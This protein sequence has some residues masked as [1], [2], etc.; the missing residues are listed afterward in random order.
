MNGLL[1]RQDFNAT[2]DRLT[3]WWSGT[4]IGRPAMLIRAPRSAPLED[5]PA[6]AEPAGWLTDYSI[7]NFEYRV[8]LTQ[9]ACINTHFMGEAMP[10]VAPDLGANCLAL[11]LGCKGVESPGTVWIEPCINDPATAAFE[12]DQKNF[13]WN[14]T[15]RLTREQLRLGKG[16]FLLQFPDLIEGLDTLA[17]MRGTESLLKDLVDRPEWVQQ[18][19]QQITRRYFEYYD[20]LFELIKDDRGGSHYCAWAP[21][22]TAKLQCDMSAMISPEMFKEFMVPVLKEMTARLDYCLYHWDGP[23][24]ICHHDQL[25]SMPKLNMIQWNPGAGNEPGS[26]KRWWPLYHK[27]IE[28]GKKMFIGCSG[29]GNLTALKKEF[30]RKIRQFMIA[31]SVE[32][33]REAEEIL[34]LASR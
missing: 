10:Y 15:L 32:S 8:N 20:A 6:M 16:K 13:Y 17:A 24:A 7:K 18:A 29:I 19:L 2:R 22:R 25:L 1:Y 12:F 31:M 28:A 26:N 34:A 33:P 21:G 4:D 30:G 3:A 14:F 5:I 23:A 9:R 11:Y 27:T